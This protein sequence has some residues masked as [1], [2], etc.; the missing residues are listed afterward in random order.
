[1]SVSVDIYTLRP[2]NQASEEHIILNS[3]GGK[4]TAPLID[5]LTNDLFG[6]TIDAALAAD[7]NLLRVLLGAKS[8]DGRD[9]ARH[10]GMVTES[11]EAYD[12][13]AGGKPEI[14]PRVEVGED[15]PGRQRINGR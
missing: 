2:V 1:M 4:L 7:L 13:A 6:Q 3:L 14:I 5:K 8:G 11:G 15:G 9:P 10:R 12:L